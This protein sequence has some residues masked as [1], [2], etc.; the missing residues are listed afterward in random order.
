VV[1]NYFKDHENVI[2]YEIINEPIQGSVY[3]SIREFLFPNYGNNHNLLPLYR[4][5]ND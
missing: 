3:H 5:V 2:G 1:A 4:K